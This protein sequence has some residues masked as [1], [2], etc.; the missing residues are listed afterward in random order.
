MIIIDNTSISDDLYLVRFCC[1]LERCLGACCVAGDAGAPLEEEEI[2]ILEDD[3]DKIKLFMT[4]RGIITVEEHGVIDYDIHGKFVTPLIND[5]ECAF[6]N[7][8]DG[9]AY[10]AIEKAYSDGKTKFQKPVSCH[11]YP[12]RITKY[13]KFDAVNYQKWNICKHALKLGN[14]EGIPL[15]KFLKEALVRKYGQRW[16]EKL[17]TEINLR[18]SDNNSL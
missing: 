3:L 8:K 12:V 4:E 1:N 7:F 16:F 9:I 10:C 13:D 2:S 6:T 11:L 17:E 14:K 15:Y 18:L 5:G